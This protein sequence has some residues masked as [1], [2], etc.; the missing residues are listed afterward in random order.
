MLAHCKRRGPLEKGDFRFPDPIFA[1]IGWFGRNAKTTP[2]DSEIIRGIGV[3]SQ[4]AKLLGKAESQS[5]NKRTAVFSRRVAQKPVWE[6]E[7]PELFRVPRSL[8]NRHR[9]VSP[10]GFEP[11]TFGFGGQRSIQLIYGDNQTPLLCLLASGIVKRMKRFGFRKTPVDST[12]R[13]ADGFAEG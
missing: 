4:P 10:T 2:P 12:I 9:P 11:V 7:W 5:L 1:K 6:G 13:A 3:G 8:K